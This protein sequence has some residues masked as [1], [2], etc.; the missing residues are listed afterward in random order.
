VAHRLV[1]D[2]DALACNLRGDVEKLG[3]TYETL[4]AHNPAFVC[5]RLTAH[6]HE[7]PRR[8]WPGYDYLP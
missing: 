8:T 7:G 5:V 3:L 4:K 1:A 6:G 2:A